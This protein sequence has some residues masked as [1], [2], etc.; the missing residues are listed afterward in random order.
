[1]KNKFVKSTDSLK[2]V[3]I[4]PA[5]ENL[6]YGMRGVAERTENGVWFSPE[7]FEGYY[8]RENIVNL[9]HLA[10]QDEQRQRVNEYL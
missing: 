10:A 9:K 8:F 5:T 3:Y 4:G 2:V 6:N 7:G 1:M